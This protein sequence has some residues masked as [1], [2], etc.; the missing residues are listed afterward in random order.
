MLPL[1]YGAIYKTPD[2]YK[3]PE[4]TNLA[5]NTN[6]PNL[7]SRDY[8][9]RPL[10][11]NVRINE[12]WECVSISTKDCEHTGNVAIA[13]NKLSGRNW[14]GTLWA[15]EKADIANGK[16]SIDPKTACF[17][18]ECTSII[19]CMEFVEPNMLLLAFNSGKLQVWSTQSEVRSPKN[20]YC[21]FMIDEKCEHMKPITCLTGF[22]TNVYKAVTGSK[23]GALKIWD[24]G[25][26]E[27]FSQQSYR[28]AHTD[29]I[30]GLSSSPINDAI[31]T[32]CSL[33]KSC[34]IW[35]DRETRPA[36]ALYSGH[37]VRFKNVCWSLDSTESLV[38]LGDES[39][40]ILTVDTRK[41][42]EFC[43]K[44]KYFDRPIRKISP[45]GEHLAV[46]ADS[47]CVKISK[48]STHEIFYENNVSQN[49]IRDCAW[50]TSSELITVGYE[51][52]L[53][54]HEIK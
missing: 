46:I 29:S 44:T 17:K 14:F 45:N 30:T 20:P 37:N 23:D 24:M 32:T 2:D 51:G 35:D 7:N 34:L 53:R 39:G 27:L 47:N 26:A 54:T 31:F 43:N 4:E 49:F 16:I 18:L 38:Y 1:M 3:P 5:N 40:N 41:P 11:H 21:P 6:Y 9:K 33:D 15:F 28:Y 48:S 36:I 50:L 19:N 52:K 42:K 25:K 22:K 12:G 13:T 8:A 10:N